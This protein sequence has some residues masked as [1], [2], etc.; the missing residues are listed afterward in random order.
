MFSVKWESLVCLSLSGVLS[1]YSWCSYSFHELASLLLIL[2]AYA[3]FMQTRTRFYHYFTFHFSFIFTTNSPSLRPSHSF[4][5]I[6]NSRIHSTFI[7][8]IKSAVQGA[9]NIINF[10][11]NVFLPSSQCHADQGIR[12]TTW[13]LEILFFYGTTFIDSNSRNW[14]I[15]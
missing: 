2:F 11:R 13:N 4:N 6:P 9:R 7:I 8:S 10:V 3:E 14:S 12:R 1:L 5:F 15:S